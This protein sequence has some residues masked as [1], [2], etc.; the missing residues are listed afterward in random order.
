MKG[1]TTGNLMN[2]GLIVRYGDEYYFTDF[3]NNEYLSKTDLEWKSKVVL[4][5]SASRNF[6]LIGNKLFFCDMGDEQK[7][8]C[9]DLTTHQVSTLV[10]DN[11]FLVNVVDDY[12]FYRNN[13]DGQRMY[14][15][16]LISN[17]NIPIT[18][19]RTWYI[20]PTKLGIFFRNYDILKLSV[21]NV[22]GSGYQVL[23]EDIPTDIIADEEYLY[24]GN[25]TQG[26]KLTK[27]KQNCKDTEQIF[28]CEDEAFSI[29]EL[30]DT[31]FYSNWSDNKTLYKIKKDGTDRCKL[32]DSPVWCINIIDRYIYYRIHGDDISLY[33]IYFDGSK[34]EKI[35]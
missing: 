19:C 32:I 20:T 11:S 17:E 25:W 24:Y 16:S 5:K 12:I 13:T 6:N 35:F 4:H 10:H 28:L 22:D 33:R 23:S 14:R 18:C 2:G 29:N 27:L 31:L 15:Y 21:V 3:S 1:N 9:I 34:N 26:K 8:K 7:I 30:G